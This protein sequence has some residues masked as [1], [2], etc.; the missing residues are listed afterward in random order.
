VQKFASCGI[1][2]PQVMQYKAEP[3]ELVSENG[4]R[5]SLVN[6]APQPVQKLASCGIALPQVTQYV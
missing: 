4:C 1:A 5:G 6:S 2:L 3:D